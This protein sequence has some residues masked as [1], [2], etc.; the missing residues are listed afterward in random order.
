MKWVSGLVMTCVACGGATPQVVGSSE[1]Q[2]TLETA[3]RFVSATSKHDIA[4]VRRMLGDPVS[5]GG[6]WFSDPACRTEFHETGDITGPRLDVLAR[7]LT[8]L[9][10]RTS[11]R[12]DALRDVAVLSDGP[13]F[14]IEARFLESAGPQT[15]SWIG[16]AA[17]LEGERMPTASASTLEALRTAGDRDGPVAG[18][19]PAVKPR[20][21]L[22]VCVDALGAVTDA[23]VRE[24][25]STAGAKAF[26]A[27]A[28]AWHFQPFLLEGQAV[29][30]CAMFAMKYPAIHESD[31]QEVLPLPL[32]MHHDEVLVP[33]NELR[34]ITAPRTSF[35]TTTPKRRSALSGTPSSS[36][37]SSCA[38]TRRAT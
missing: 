2:P 35:R 18:L 26:V 32:P 13:G 23:D 11:R 19:D 8:T 5:Y 21:W 3:Q 20:V 37:A 30:V 1:P 15:L 14:E 10:L 27:A 28:R 34:R 12:R 17:R 4:A 29:P 33:Q 25:T 31:E 9:D 38:S 16:Y 7:C 36:G 24:T 22:K 6:L